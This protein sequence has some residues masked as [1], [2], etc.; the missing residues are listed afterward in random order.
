[1]ATSTRR[2][3]AISSKFSF[4]KLVRKMSIKSDTS[5]QSVSPKSPVSALP[6][7]TTIETHVK[8]ESEEYE[9]EDE[10]EEETIPVFTRK[11]RLNSQS[12]ESE[13]AKYTN[14]W[15]EWDAGYAAVSFY[16]SSRN[17]FPRKWL[18]DGIS[19]FCFV[20]LLFFLS[21]K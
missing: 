5:D 20:S 15:K 21:R 3:S 19:F 13:I 11:A 8:T 18:T 10:E 1:M 2:P 16:G 4:S 12:P 14:S 9:E 6:V 17:K 7:L